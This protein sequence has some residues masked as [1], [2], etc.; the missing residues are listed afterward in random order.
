VCACTWKISDKE[1][2]KNISVISCVGSGEEELEKGTYF[3][4]SCVKI[5]G[6]NFM[7]CSLHSIE[8]WNHNAWI[9]EKKKK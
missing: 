7:I 8:E 1:R 9:K 2:H 3:A 4:T 5:K 6:K